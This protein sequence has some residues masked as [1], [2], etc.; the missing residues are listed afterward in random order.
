KWVGPV[1]IFSELDPLGEKTPTQ[2]MTEKQ[3]DILGL[4]RLNVEEDSSSSS[5]DQ[6][7]C[8]SAGHISIETVM[9]SGEE[10]ALSGS[11][12]E[13]YKCSQGGGSF[14]Q[15]TGGSRGGMDS[16]VEGPLGAGAEEEGGLCGQ[17]GRRASTGLPAM[18]W[19]LQLQARN[20]QPEQISLVSE[21]GY[22]PM[23]LD[24]DS[25]DTIDSGVFV[26][27]DCSSPVNTNFD[28]EEQID[29]ALLS[30][31]GS[32]PSEYVKQW[33]TG[34]TMQEDPTN[35]GQNRTI[36]MMLDFTHSF[37][38]SERCPIHKTH[39][40]ALQTHAK[41]KLLLALC[42]VW[43]IIQLSEGCSSGEMTDRLTC[44]SDYWFTITCTLSI[45]DKPA[46][47]N[48]TQYWLYF[49]WSDEDGITFKCPLV[50]MVDSYGCTFVAHFDNNL[51]YHGSSFNT[52]DCFHVHL[53][54]NID[55]QIN[56]DNL[57]DFEPSKNSKFPVKIMLICN[58]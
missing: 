57:T 44:V 49:T 31:V 2:M 22:P 39:A 33:M 13:T 10:G 34:K 43:N 25:V 54:Y 48:Y 1:F 9:V 38:L 8:H 52:M 40:Q 4:S 3:L 50:E 29:S 28:S 58:A 42:A 7:A 35:S 17:S 16:E 15:Y 56:Y 32:S 27:S 41:M 36:V 18:E 20:N 37:I 45:T 12:W 6:G 24:L 21:D 55:C 47:V 30:G 23:M 53:C 26:E 5:G 51:M 46:G 11:S 19:Q 14:S